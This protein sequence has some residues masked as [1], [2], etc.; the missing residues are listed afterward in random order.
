[1]IALRVVYYA[2]PIWFGISSSLTRYTRAIAFSFALLFISVLINASYAAERDTTFLYSN[3][4]D[5]FVD[6]KP[7][8]PIFIEGGTLIDGTGAA[9]RENPGIL[10]KDGLLT[11]GPVSSRPVDAVEIDASEKWILPGLFDLH[12]H[13]TF[14]LP[15]AFH[16]EDDLLSGIRA[17]RFLEH[18]QEIGVTTVCDVASRNNV[19]FSMKRAQRMGLMG[20]SRLF[21]TG[22][23]ITVTGGHP[24]EFQPYEDSHYG[25]EGDGPW[26]LRKLV[27]TAVKK[28]ADFIKVFPPLTVAEYKAVVDEAHAWKLRVTAHAGGIQDL[29][30]TSGSRAVD[31]GVDS[32]HHL[33]PY[34][35]NRDQIFLKMARDGIHVIPTIGYHLREV[36]GSEHI[37]GNWMEDNIGHN[38][39]SVMSTFRAMQ[40]AGV[41]FGVGTESNPFNML[42]IADIYAEELEG[43]IHAGFSAMQVIRSATLHSAEVLG[44]RE[45]AGSIETGKWADLLI[46]NENPLEDLRALVTPQ[47]VIQAGNVV[48]QE[49][50][51]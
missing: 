25:V 2:P 39:G 31:A 26:E 50:S 23:G 22:P 12:A 9:P 47:L 35:E 29:S 24:T 27:R 5:Q 37:R 28:G 38:Y 10:V 32:I 43:F 49:R 40:E 6:D 42:T 16:V 36:K 18:Y 41:S 3:D 8:R 11:L 46:I 34:G 21:V 33:H 20:G 7:A 45:K 15:G 48:H 51:H 13:L 14:Y 30:T 44:L 17:E 4:V 19:G 1:M